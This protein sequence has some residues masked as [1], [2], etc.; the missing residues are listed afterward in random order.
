[1]TA[2]KRELIVG[3]VFTGALV[4]LGVFTIILGNYNPLKPP[5]TLYV[6]FEDVG[7]LRKGNVVRIAGLEVGQVDE[8]Q[9]KP[10]GVLAKLRLQPGVELHEGYSIKV[11]AF[12]PLGGKYVDI[13]RGNLAGPVVFDPPPEDP[14]HP[15][16]D[17][18]VLRGKTEAEFISELADFAEKA[19]PKLLEF[20]DNLVAITD[21]VKNME[22]TV[23]RLIG[24]PTMYEH[25]VK[26]SANLDR[27]TQQAT[28]LIDKI[29]SGTGTLGKLVNDD[30][31]YEATTGTME[32]VRSVAEKVDAGRGTVGA[33]FNDEALRASVARTVEHIESILAAADRGEGSIGRLV[34]DEKLY[35]NLAAALAGLRKTMDMIAEAKGPIGVL[36]NDE[37]AG[38]NVRRTLAHVE[39]VSDALASGKGTLGRLIMDDRLVGEAERILVEIRESVE[40]LREQAPINSF[41]TAIFQA[42]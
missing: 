30:R 3:L 2:T 27:A 5:K 24:D 37:Q 21:K 10:K 20:S 13:E 17:P 7:G 40:D 26:A 29:N 6:F 15:E 25:L 36:V 22:G 41:V 23:G 9:L 39:K 32:R 12:S 14:E 19:K 4:A 28:S 1:M 33:L 8:M 11:R 42:F 18:H 16:N 31:L 34:R 35:D 38:E